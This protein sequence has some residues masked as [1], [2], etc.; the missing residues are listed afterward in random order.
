M[1]GKSLDQVTDM[2]VANAANL[3]I[4]VKPA[5]LANTL[6]RAGPAAASRRSNTL[7]H[8]SEARFATAAVKGSNLLDLRDQSWDVVADLRPIIATMRTW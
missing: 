1:A 6:S 5:N 8:H 3:I 7:S 4:T 2:M